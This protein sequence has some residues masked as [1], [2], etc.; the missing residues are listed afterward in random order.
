LK[1]VVQDG[2][3][4]DTTVSN[5]NLVISVDQDDFVKPFAKLTLLGDQEII[6]SHGLV[7]NTEFDGWFTLATS[8]YISNNFNN[9][10]DWITE[11][12]RSG[13]DGN[14]ITTL[15]INKTGRYRISMNYN[16]D[17]NYGVHAIRGIVFCDDND[18]LVLLDDKPYGVPT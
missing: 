7:Q 12:S 4:I 13:I 9:R 18:H 11:S 6:R 17:I 15:R 3:G 16:G 10:S 1:D 8:N 5:C 2:F 14:T